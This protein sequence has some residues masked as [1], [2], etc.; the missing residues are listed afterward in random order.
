MIGGNIPSFHPYDP[1]QSSGEPCTHQYGVPM[2]ESLLCKVL[3]F[4]ADTPKSATR[5]R[6]HNDE[7]TSAEIYF[8]SFTRHV[9][10]EPS[11]KAS[12]PLSPPH[13]VVSKVMEL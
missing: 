3:L 4:F 8:L 11:S 6:R 12:N 2:K 10:A 1:T 13:T 7:G 9:G 5:I